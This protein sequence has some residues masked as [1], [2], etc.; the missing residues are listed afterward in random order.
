[1][2]GSLLDIPFIVVLGIFCSITV[3][4]MFSFMSQF[5]DVYQELPEDPFNNESKVSFQRGVDSFLFWDQA[6]ILLITGL[7]ISSIIGAAFLN[8]HPIFF[9]VSIILLFVFIFI[10]AQAA[11]VFLAIMEHASIAPYANQFPYIITFYQNL[12]LIILAFMGVMMVVMYAFG[13][14]RGGGI[15]L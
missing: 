15:S 11:N 13:G 6:L 2:K 1:M 7:M 14:R 5:N 12:P 9:I 8:T 4:F 10:G 3:I